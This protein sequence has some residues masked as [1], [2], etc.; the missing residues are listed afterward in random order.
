MGGHL[1]TVNVFQGQHI[2]AAVTGRFLY[3][4]WISFKSSETG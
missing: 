1:N 3:Y 2:A 4:S